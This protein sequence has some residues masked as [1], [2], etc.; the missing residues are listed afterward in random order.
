MLV[1]LVGS[2]LLDAATKTLSRPLSLGMAMAFEMPKY[3]NFYLNYMV[4]QWMSSCLELTRYINFIKF[5]TFRRTNPEERAR[6]LAEPE[7]QDYY[8]IGSRSARWTANALMGLV[9]C[10]ICP[11]ICAVTF[12]NF[13]LCK[14]VYGYLIVFAET[15][16]VDLGGAFWVNKCRHLLAGL[17]IFWLLMCGE[18]TARAQPRQALM[19]LFSGVYLLWAM[20]RFANLRWLTLPFEEVVDQPPDLQMAGSYVQP[21]LRG[22]RRRTGFTKKATMLF[23]YPDE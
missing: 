14:L 20:R 7:D 10:P 4:S 23:S 12:V 18:L 9:F 13:F 3:S 15:R 2:S 17:W 22:D 16:K 8:G 5:L 21:E 1:T 6:E 19:A 11:L